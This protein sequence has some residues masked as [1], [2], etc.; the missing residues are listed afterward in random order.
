[1]PKIPEAAKISDQLERKD[2]EKRHKIILD[3]QRGI[4]RKLRNI[5]THAKN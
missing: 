3:L 5:K 1:M 2:L 4:S